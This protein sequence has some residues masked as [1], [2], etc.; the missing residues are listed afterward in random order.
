[1]RIRSKLFMAR[2]HQNV[3]KLPFQVLLAISS[4]FIVQT[5]TSGT[6]TSRRARGSP[7]QSWTFNP[8]T[9]GPLDIQQIR[10]GGVTANRITEPATQCVPQS[11]GGNYKMRNRSKLF[12]LGSHSKFTLKC[13]R[14]CHFK[15]FWLYHQYLLFKQ[16]IMEERHQYGRKEL[17]YRATLSIQKLEAPLTLN[18]SDEVRSTTSE[19]ITLAIGFCIIAF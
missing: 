8:K 7:V 11:T 6:E 3:K 12:M 5:G 14:N 13:E 2:Y 9:G 16:E 10:R 1:M 17:K 19:V 4:L 18:E 15:Y